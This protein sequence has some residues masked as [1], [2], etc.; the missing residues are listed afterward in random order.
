MESE[1]TA[2]GNMSTLPIAIVSLDELLEAKETIEAAEENDRNKIDSFLDI[3]QV[4][5]RS[6]LLIWSGL[7]FPE[8]YVMYTIQ[9]NPPPKCSDGNTRRTLDYVSFL[10]P[11]FSIVNAVAQLESKLPGMQ[12]SYSYTDTYMFN[13]HV[14]KK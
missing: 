9:F 1:T 10:L 13:I 5:I 14:S 4:A 7:G 2:V 3:D 11:D 12:L 8:N 6:R